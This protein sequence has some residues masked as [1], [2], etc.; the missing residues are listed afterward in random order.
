M[1]SLPFQITSSV[2]MVA[3][4]THTRSLPDNPFDGA[5]HPP[6]PP[7]GGEVEMLDSRSCDRRVARIFFFFSCA[8]SYYIPHLNRRWQRWPG[9]FG[10]FYKCRF[11]MIKGVWPRIIN[12]KIK[13]TKQQ[14]QRH[15]HLVS[16]NINGQ[17]TPLSFVLLTAL[18]G[19]FFRVLIG[20]WWNKI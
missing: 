7:P 11:S 3:R 12:G 1:K 16:S 8:S 18:V 10:A 4:R 9:P 5:Y 19:M 2:A 6:P 15:N 20:P 13:I 14:Q 17:S